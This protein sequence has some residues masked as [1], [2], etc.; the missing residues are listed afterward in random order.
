MKKVYFI[1]IISAYEDVFKERKINLKKIN[2][3]ISEIKE[4]TA[5]LKKIRR[6]QIISQN[7][8]QSIRVYNPVG[9]SKGF[10]NSRTMMF[11]FSKEEAEKALKTNYADL[12]EGGSWGNPTFAVIEEYHQG[13][14]LVKNRWFYLIEFNKNNFKVNSIKEPLWAKGTTNYAL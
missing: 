14:C 13:F 5:F 9:E 10:R 8:K 4:K 12:L 11:F 2:K 1:T 7:I 6:R 3:E